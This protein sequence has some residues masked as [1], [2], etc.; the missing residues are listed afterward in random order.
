M[1]LIHAITAALAPCGLNLIGT[2]TVATYETLVPKQY[3][4]TPLM[5]R[6]RT[7][8]VI[9]NGGGDFW[10]RFRTYCDTRPGYLENHEHPLD[11]YTAELI[12]R[13]LTPLLKEA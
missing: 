5:P 6:G 2:T 7:L 9:G 8:V 10:E 3:H 13:M 12:E 11:E 1:D 4:V